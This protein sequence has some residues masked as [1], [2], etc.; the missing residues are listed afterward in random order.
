MPSIGV[1]FYTNEEGQF[2]LKYPEGWVVQE[3]PAE[4]QSLRI[5][6]ITPEAGDEPER[7]TIVFGPGRGQSAEQ[8]WV[9][10]LCFIQSVHGDEVEDWYLGEA[11]S[12]SIG[13]HHARQIPFRFTHARSES[14]WQGLVTGVVYDSTN[15][16]VIA[17]APASR[18]M[19]AWYFFERILDSIQ[20][21]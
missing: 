4:G 11:Y 3:S 14:D 5:V 2:H 20:F 21:L 15:Y 13:G 7:I 16:A 1:Q 8:V 18:W 12:M 10:G 17:E 9:T 6:M 19:W